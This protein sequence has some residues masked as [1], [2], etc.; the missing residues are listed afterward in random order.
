MGQWWTELTLLEQILYYIAIPATLVLCLQTIMTF[1]GMDDEID[2]VDSGDIDDV[3]GD[4]DSDF[5]ISFQ[6]F[7][8]R[9][10]VAFF[11]FFGWGGI[12]AASIDYTPLMIVITSIVFGL[13]AMMISA[14]FFYFMRKMTNNGNLVIKHAIGKVGEVYLTIPKNREGMGKVNVV[15]QGALRELQAVTDELVEIPTGKSIIVLGVLDHS[16]VIVKANT[17]QEV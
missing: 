16:T 17:K 7:T 1:I 8:V 5:E 14:S 9:N 15:V 12:W 13:V 4:F 6:M 3:D 11:T 2:S 10:F